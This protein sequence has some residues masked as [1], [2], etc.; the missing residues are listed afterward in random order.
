VKAVAASV[1]DR[2][3]IKHP[4]GRLSRVALAALVLAGVTEVR[5]DG[6]LCRNRLVF[7]DSSFWSLRLTFPISG[8]DAD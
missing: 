1:V 7:P 6:G 4:P 5:S 3:G 2:T 8:E